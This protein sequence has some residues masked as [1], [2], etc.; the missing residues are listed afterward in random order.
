MSALCLMSYELC[1]LTFRLTYFLIQQNIN[2]YRLLMDSR[3][4]GR[5]LEINYHIKLLLTFKYLN[6]SPRFKILIK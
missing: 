1:I 6:Y 5:L 3:I 2:K 4:V